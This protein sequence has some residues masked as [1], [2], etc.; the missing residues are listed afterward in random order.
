[1]RASDIDTPYQRR[2]DYEEKEK[3]ASLLELKLGSEMIGR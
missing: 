3:S 2:H 1:L